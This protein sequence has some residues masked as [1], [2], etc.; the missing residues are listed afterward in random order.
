[1]VLK[2]QRLRDQI[3]YKHETLGKV[4][5]IHMLLSQCQEYQLKQATVRGLGTSSRL[6]IR[7]LLDHAEH[8]PAFRRMR[9]MPALPGVHTR[10]MTE[11][12]PRTPQIM[13]TGQ[14]TMEATT[15]GT[16]YHAG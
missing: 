4:H 3:L 12:G 8:R 13:S 7:R 9:R 14:R 11:A 16:M 1:M 10:G 5:V 15:N 6:E 2:V